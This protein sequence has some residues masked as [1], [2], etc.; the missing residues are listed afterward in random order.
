MVKQYPLNEVRKIRDLKD[1]LAQSMELYPQKNLFLVKK[2]HGEPYEGITFATFN[3]NVRELGTAFLSM[4]LGEK[5]IAVI[6]ENRYEWAVTYLAVMNGTSM[7]VPMDKELPAED[8][9]NLLKMAD[10]SAIVYSGKLASVMERMR[11]ELPGMEYWINMDLEA[12]TD[13]EKSFCALLDLG[14]S[15][16]DGGDDTFDKVE[17]DPEQARV[18]LFTSGT[19]SFPKGV[20][21]CHKNIVTNLMDMCSMTYIDEKD[22][23]LSVLPLHHTYECTCGFLCEV[24][25]GSTIAY[26]EG[27]KHILPNMKEAQATMMLGVPAL[28]ETMYK[29]VWAA[30]KKNGIDGKL[31]TGMKLSNALRCI[32]IDLR[33]KIFAKVHENFG[34]HMRLLVCGAAAVDPEVSKGFR[35]M[36]IAFLQGYGITECSPIVALNRD[37]CFK[38]EAA[39]LPLPTLAVE[40]LDKDDE[41]IGEIV[42]KGDNVMLGYYNNEEAT[43]EAFEGGWF[44]TGDLG[45]IDA[46]GFVHITGRKKNVI[47][48]KN[49]KNIFPEELET[50]LN[51]DPNVLESLVVGEFNPED[52]ETYLCAQM[53]PNYDYIRENEGKDVSDDRIR[54]MMESVVR[55]VNERNPLYKYIRRVEV[56]ETEFVKTTTKKIKRYVVNK[57]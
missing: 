45:Y 12:D 51:R 55:V 18:L 24:Y 35:D 41:G 48:T 14:K 7:I 8:I 11:E 21:L 30:A 56:R 4:G 50:L 29:R 27:L 5:K 53:V 57:K 16:L 37:R 39:G 9:C 25:R 40:I 49:G 34:G 33:R 31:R 17:I 23:F 43:A 42:C 28:F 15:M 2:K 10:A 47:V 1:M 32:G 36:G 46:Q 19:T 54:E 20:L 44:H 26:C 3:Q 38:D 6:G 13:T 52:G 22:I